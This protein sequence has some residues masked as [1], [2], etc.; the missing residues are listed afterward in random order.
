VISQIWE[1]TTVKRTKT[2]P[3]RGQPLTNPVD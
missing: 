2:D 3:A 1:A